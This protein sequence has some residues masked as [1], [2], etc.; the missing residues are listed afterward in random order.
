LTF[1]ISLKAV[2]YGI[3]TQPKKIR[4]TLARK[5]VE[6]A[7][8]DTSLSG[9]HA[10]EVASYGKTLSGME[11]RIRQYHACLLTM[12]HGA[13]FKPFLARVYVLHKNG[14]DQK[15]KLNFIEVC[16]IAGKHVEE[17][18]IEIFIKALQD[19]DA[20]AIFEIAKAIK[21]FGRPKYPFIPADHERSTILWLKE[22]SDSNDPYT[23]RDVAEAIAGGKPVGPS[24]D[25]FS[26]LRRKCAQL[27]LPLANSR[28][29][30]KNHKSK[31]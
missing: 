20:E 27:G 21:F 17:G 9:Y 30:K 31:S 29:I 15:R 26:A 16:K 19:G 6:L 22:H 28:K 7:K 11:E 8:I 5:I 3:A 25:G 14:R 18:L 24:E 10:K 13:S 1:K 23:I 4:S 12:K 2:F